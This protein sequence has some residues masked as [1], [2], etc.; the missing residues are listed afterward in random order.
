MFKI[1]DGEPNRTESHIYVF[2]YCQKSLRDV[3]NDY[4]I[5]GRPMP[6]DQITSYMK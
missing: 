4:K 6:I 3:I 5:L 2:E 1:V